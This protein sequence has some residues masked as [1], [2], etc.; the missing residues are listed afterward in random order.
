[1]LWVRGCYF[2]KQRTSVV[3]GLSLAM[4]SFR[5]GLL[6]CG[7]QGG[8]GGKP[9]TNAEGCRSLSTG[10]EPDGGDP[11]LGS[12]FLL[13]LQLD[14][15]CHHTGGLRYL[16]FARPHSSATRNNFVQVFSHSHTALILIRN[17]RIHTSSPARQ[18][19]FHHLQ[20]TEESRL[21][22]KGSREVRKRACCEFWSAR[23]L[24]MAVCLI[25]LVV[26]GA[27]LAVKLS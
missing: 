7:M 4:P 3:W 18:R 20:L 13:V 5:F 26:A 23:L 17:R 21:F 24:C 10:A 12:L 2:A 16:F 6:S 22:E 9:A 19:T 8:R 25:V 11:W 15:R 1:M 27:I 14:S